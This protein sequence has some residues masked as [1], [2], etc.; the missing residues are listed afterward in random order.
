MNLLY[1]CDDCAREFII[2]DGFD[3]DTETV[4]LVPKVYPPYC[5][6]CGKKDGIKFVR[7]CD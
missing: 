5:P 4:L 1:Q 2:N 6:Y 7:E 3:E